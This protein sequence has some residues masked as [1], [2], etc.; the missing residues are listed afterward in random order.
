M[1]QTENPFF[2]QIFFILISQLVAI[3]FYRYLSTNGQHFQVLS[4]LTF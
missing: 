2:S 3:T 1:K 4:F